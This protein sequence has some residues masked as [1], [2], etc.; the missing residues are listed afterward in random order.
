MKPHEREFFIARIFDGRLKYKSNSGGTLFLHPMDI[1]EIYECQEVHKDAYNEALWNEVLTEEEMMEAMLQVGIWSSKKDSQ[2]KGIQKDIEELKVQIFKSNF[3]P[4]RKEKVRRTLRLAEKKLLELLNDKHSYSF[5]TCNGYAI[6]CREHWVVEN[7]TRYPDGTPY[8]WGED[9]I[10]EVLKFK[11]NE[12]L[13]DS[14]LREIAKSG[15]WKT[16]WSTSKKQGAIFGKSGI[17]LTD[18]Q[19]SLIAWSLMYDNI[20]ES[21]E[22]PADKLVDDDDALDGWMIIQ[23]RKR[24]KDMGQGSADEIIGNEKIRN[25]E[26]IFIMTENTEESMAEVDALN[27]SQGTAIKRS[28]FKQLEKAGDKR[29]RHGDFTDVKRGKQMQATNQLRDSIKGRS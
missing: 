10:P 16:I 6:F 8:D 21:P 20:H 26:E 7:T 14:S 15:E 13:E 23:R 1:G 11:Q 18:E 17:E 12:R 27:T 2:I 3:K 25:S 22:C 29:V 19:R 4:E 9:T 5:A 28:R 24:E